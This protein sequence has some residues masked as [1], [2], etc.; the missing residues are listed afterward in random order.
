MTMSAIDIAGLDGG[1]VSL[2]SKQLDELA[3]VS[4]G[5]CCAPDMRAGMM[6]Y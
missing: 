5:R 2:T 3:R 1:R 6:L 4:R